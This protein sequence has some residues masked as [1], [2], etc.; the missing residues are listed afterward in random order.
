M[1]RLRSLVARVLV[2]LGLASTDPG[3]LDECPWCGR[4]LDDDPGAWF[5]ADHIAAWLDDPA[6]T[7]EVHRLRTHIDQIDDN[8]HP[9]RRTTMTIEPATIV[10]AFR[11]KPVIVEAA[12]WDG[13]AAGATPIIDWILG[14]GGTATWRCDQ[15]GN[16]GC[17][18][19][20]VHTIAIQTL[21]GV[22]HA[23]PGDWI[24]RGIHGEFYPCKPDIFTATYEETP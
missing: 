8:N 2:W 13:T 9:A 24:I 22:M 20:G 5:T 15:P 17:D 23:S 18:P 21:E 19:H 3:D 16:T 10:R 11:K 6:N 12:Q 1:T 14:N 7:A 4:P